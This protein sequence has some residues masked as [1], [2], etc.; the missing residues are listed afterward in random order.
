MG[1]FTTNRI[2]KACM[3]E[4]RGRKLEVD[5]L[6][7]G[8]GGYDMIIDMTLL[9]KYHAVIDCKNKRVVFRIPH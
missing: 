4:L 8:T 3:V 9:S 1:V 2:S 7:L 5:M 6:V